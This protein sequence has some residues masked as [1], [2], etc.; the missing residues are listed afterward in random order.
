MKALPQPPADEWKK[1]PASGAQ[2]LDHWTLTPVADYSGA[3][4]VASRGKI[5]RDG[6]DAQDLLKITV[7]ERALIF[8]RCLADLRC[9][10]DE[11]VL[12]WLK[13]KAAAEELL[14]ACLGYLRKHAKQL[15][16]PDEKA[17]K[18]DGLK[19]AQVV[20][21]ARRLGEVMRGELLGVAR[22]LLK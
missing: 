12:K 3:L 18:M 21:R 5:A 22:K 15:S 19:A 14:R 6:E 20:V 7:C 4:I 9:V 17:L 1:L 16:V 13:P 2:P 10:L 8:A 11:I